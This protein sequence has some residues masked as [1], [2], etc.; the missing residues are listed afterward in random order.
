MAAKVTC[1]RWYSAFLA[2]WVTL[3]LGPLGHRDSVC[4]SL[5]SSKVGAAISIPLGRLWMGESTRWPGEEGSRIRKL[6]I[7]ALAKLAAPWAS[8]TASWG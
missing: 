4:P 8:G 1:H 2:P 6:R 7:L 5:G 3:G